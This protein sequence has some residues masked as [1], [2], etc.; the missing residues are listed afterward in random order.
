MT[1][2][3]FPR[4]RFDDCDPEYYVLLIL[5]AGVTVG[6]LQ[7][8]LGCKPRNYQNLEQ[9]KASSLVYLN[10]KYCQSCYTVQVE[11]AFLI[12][13]S[14]RLGLNDRILST[15]RSIN[16]PDPPFES[17]TLVTVFPVPSRGEVNTP[18]SLWAPGSE[19]WEHEVPLPS[20]HISGQVNKEL[21]QTADHLSTPFSELFL[22]A[23]QKTTPFGTSL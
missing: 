11:N 15:Y 18:V 4:S 9:R 2:G 23:R 16:T 14:A 3:K 19:M 6:Q 13:L 5:M 10:A 20:Q 21:V 1:L 12:S 22:A 8:D 7:T 17:P